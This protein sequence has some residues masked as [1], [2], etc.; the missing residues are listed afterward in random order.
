MEKRISIEIKPEIIKWAVNSAGFKNVE[1]SKKISEKE[2]TV[3]EWLSGKV[4]PTLKQ[5][6]KLAYLVKRPLASLLLPIVPEEK[7][8][9][10]DFRMLPDKVDKFERKTIF[11]IRKARSLQKLSKELSIFV[12]EE[13][14]SKV[15]E[16]KITENAKDIALLYRKTLSME[17]KQLKFKNPY[18]LYH[19]LRRFLE[20]F[21]IFVFQ[22][23]MPLEDARGFAL[24]DEK[25]SVIVLNSKDIIE[26]RIFTLMHEFGHILLGETGIDIPELS[27][28]NVIEKWCNTF[29][30]NF[31]L[32]EEVAK[33]IFEEE[34]DKLT[35]NKTLNYF[36]RKYK[37]SKSMLLYSM[38]KLG[39]I[40]E[41]LFNDIME[42][43]R[44]AVFEEKK[45][46][47]IPIETKRLSEMGNKFVS[48][49]ANNLDKRNITYSDA[50]NY[51]S[52]KSKKLDKL[53]GKAIR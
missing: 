12:N 3:D 34:K 33:K 19:H 49:V 9:P 43:F 4:K 18:E 35:E 53:L 29:S 10:K 47:S 40:S 24:S 8:L 2:S 31:L 15:G 27:S 39:F 37:V 51:L 38:F 16:V 52:I 44:K 42:R 1:I 5:L 50:L 36:S 6:E 7:P 20:D 32:P 30:S 13:T 46:G 11:A 45:S 14:K 28:N 22:I 26:A 21:N 41:G 25:P 17:E 23:S 48:L